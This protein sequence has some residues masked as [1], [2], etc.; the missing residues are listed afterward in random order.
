[1]SEKSYPASQKRPKAACQE[2]SDN[3]IVEKAGLQE[4]FLTKNLILLDTNLR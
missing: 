1:V 4:K 2:H 3:F